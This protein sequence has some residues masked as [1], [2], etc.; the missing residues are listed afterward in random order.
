MEDLA[1]NIFSNS[2]KSKLSKKDFDEVSIRS[3]KKNI[4][5][6]NKNIDSTISIS[7]NMDEPRASDAFT[8][9]MKG[10][11]DLSKRI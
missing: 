3:S 7:K 9:V 6:T 10:I 4:S 1:L 8:N 2:R 11:L 5:T